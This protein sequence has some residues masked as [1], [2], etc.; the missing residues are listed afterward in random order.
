MT[1]KAETVWSQRRKRSAMNSKT[2]ANTEI[3]VRSVRSSPSANRESGFIV[4]M[5]DVPD[6][7]K[8]QQENLQEHTKSTEEQQLT[9]QQ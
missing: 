1:P 5:E 7:V 2:E 8:Q 9:Y 3:N 4:C 6:L